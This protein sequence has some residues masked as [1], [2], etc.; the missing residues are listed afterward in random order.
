MV[1]QTEI[2]S[3]IIRGYLI[4]Q[5]IEILVNISNCKPI[6]LVAQEIIWSND[7]NKLDYKSHNLK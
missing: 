3:M 1:W 4:M 7:G 5:H 6:S 2:V